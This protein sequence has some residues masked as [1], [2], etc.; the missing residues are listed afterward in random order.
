MLVGDWLYV[1]KRASTRHAIAAS[2]LVTYRSPDDGS[3]VLKRVVGVKGDI[4]RMRHDTLI[5]GSG[6]ACRRNER[7][8]T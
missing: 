7:Y 3:I 2:A 5:P 1:D 6:S 4:L 8:A